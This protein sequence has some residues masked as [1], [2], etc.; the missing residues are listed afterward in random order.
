MQAEFGDVREGAGDRLHGP[1][2]GDVGKP[3]HHR[4]ASL[5]AAQGRHDPRLAGLGGKRLVV[6]PQQRREGVV[7]AA[8]D[9]IAQSATLLQYTAGQ[10]RAV[11]EHGLQHRLAG[12]VGADPVDKFPGLRVVGERLVQPEQPGGGAV[13]MRRLGQPAG[14]D[15]VQQM[16]HDLPGRVPGKLRYEGSMV[17]LRAMHYPCCPIVRQAGN[18]GLSWSAE[19]H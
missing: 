18:N 5:D 14:V 4:R 7:G 16:R 8:F 19:H 11:P 2:P 13:R 10:I 15:T 6:F 9:E 17:K 12:R 1:Q 3:G